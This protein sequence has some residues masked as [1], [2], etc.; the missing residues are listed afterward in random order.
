MEFSTATWPLGTPGHSWI[1][2]AC[3]ITGIGHKSLLFSSKVI[4]ASAV[5]LLT[6][7]GLLE[8]AWVEQR[9]RTSGRKYRSPLPSEAKPPLDMW[10]KNG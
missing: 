10:G 8:E 2:V 5:D 7:P 3:S 1:N 4:A 6:E 9:R